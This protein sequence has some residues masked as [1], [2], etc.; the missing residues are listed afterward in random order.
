MIWVITLVILFTVLS[1]LFWSTDVWKNEKAMKYISVISVIST[2][3]FIVSIVLSIERGNEDRK[4]RNNE[5]DKKRSADFINETE[6]NW[7]ELEKYFSNNYP[8]LEQ[9]YKELYP[10]N[11]T[12]PSI[13]LTDA[14]KTQSAYKQL[15]ACE[16]LYQTIE[17]LINTEPDIQKEGYGWFKIFSNWSK[18]NIFRTNWQSSRSFNN[19]TTQKFIDR[20]ISNN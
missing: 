4:R 6:K 18:S 8:Y 7:I 17:N 15:H 1:I 9:L 20:L 19:P 10:E 11:N 12:L 5:D 2:L 14:D 16:I 3:V 13:T